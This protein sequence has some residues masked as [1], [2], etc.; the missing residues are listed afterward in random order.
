[1]SNRPNILLIILDSL[2]AKNVDIYGYDRRTMPFLSEYSANAT[3]YKHARSASIHSVA[4]HASMW[5]GQSLAEH[6]AWSHYSFIPP[7]DTVWADLSDSGYQTGLFTGNYILTKTSNLS[8]PFDYVVTDDY[9]NTGQ[10]LFENAYHPLKSVSRD[11]WLGNLKMSI[12]DE[13]PI[14][15]LA[16]AAYHLS[17]KL[18]NNF[19]KSKNSGQHIQAFLR[20]Q[21]S[22]TQPWA[23][24]I[25]LLDTHY[26]Y[27]PASEHDHWD[28]STARSI[29]T[30]IEGPMSQEFASGNLTE[31]A[32][33]KNLYDGAICEA[34]AH[35]RKLIQ[36]LKKTGDHN[37][38]L[39]IV[40]S[41]H[42]EGFGEQS[43]ITDAKMV[44]HSWGLHEVLT[45][46]PLVVKYPSQTE[47]H[48]IIEPVSLTAFRETANAV[49]NGDVEVNSFVQGYDVMASTWR[50]LRKNEDIFEPSEIKPTDYFGPWRA[51]YRFEDGI[52]RKYIR[53][54]N[55]SATVDIPS[56][57]EQIIRGGDDRGVVDE[58][59]DKF[60]RDQEVLETPEI[61]R[62]SEAIEHRLRDLGYLI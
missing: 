56:A 34:D 41:D 60:G 49:A 17:L 47:G 40:T 13:Y 10:K 62:H 11:G 54:G 3:L 31:I 8:A 50:L 42:G 30:Q 16:N 15:S 21:R 43:L 45:H 53:R 2:R 29:Q 44:D 61:D 35:V 58:V 51:V 24:C 38:T 12:A 23:A 39:V 32:K 48:E 28:D 59:F 33:L 57:Q 18:I 9:M 7:D 46:V 14:K 37:N 25:N 36:E 4:S 26:P 27:E 20:W 5:T 52:V 1:M 6:M 22:Q 19:V 55:H